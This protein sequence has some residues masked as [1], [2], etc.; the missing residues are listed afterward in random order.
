[1]ESRA[2]SSHPR[3]RRLV[4]LAALAGL[5]AG[6][7]GCSHA[8]PAVAAA[9]EPARAPEPAP[10]VQPAAQVTPPPAPPAPIAVKTESI[11]FDFDRS[12]LEPAGE[13]FLSEFGTLL[14]RHP[15]LHVR[16]EGNCDER[17][18]AQY[19]V[20]LGFRRAEAAKRYLLQMGARDGQVKTISY[21]KE[22]PR[23]TGH[24]EA[25]WSQ[26]RR[27]DFVPDH[28]TLPVAENP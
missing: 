18:T 7:A 11:Y 17:G 3:I 24:G 8:K 13:P 1:M 16:V 27:D 22:R 23:A 20:A 26:N 10:V 12:D 21:G 9:P 28:A 2:G 19:N 5:L 4:E 14:A 25:A 15:D 6:V